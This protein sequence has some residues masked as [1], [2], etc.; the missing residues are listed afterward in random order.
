MLY[1][2]SKTPSSIDIF[3]IFADNNGKLS[4][5]Y[6]SINP[7]FKLSKTFIMFILVSII[8]FLLIASIL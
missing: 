7:F 3:P 5:L 6:T 8:L 4:S 1:L 2:I